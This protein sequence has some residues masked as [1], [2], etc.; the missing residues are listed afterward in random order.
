MLHE[1]QPE[2]TLHT[3]TQKKA[4]VLGVGL[5]VIFFKKKPHHLHH[6]VVFLIRNGKDKSEPDT[7]LRLANE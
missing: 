3:H 6:Y 5:W 4:V 2:S 7:S 1:Q